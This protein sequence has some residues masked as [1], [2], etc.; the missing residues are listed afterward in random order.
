MLWECLVTRSLLVFV[1]TAA[2]RSQNN[3]NYDY[4]S[5]QIPEIGS[6]MSTQNS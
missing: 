3:N 5:Y 2:H 6:I 1:S 4:L